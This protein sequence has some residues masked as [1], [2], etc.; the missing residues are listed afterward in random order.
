MEPTGNAASL[1]AVK[2]SN[3]IIGSGDAS[4][5]E[6]IEGTRKGLL[7]SRFSG[8]MRI[9]DGVVSGTVK[10]AIL[11]ENGERKFPV[12]ECM[13]VGNMYEFLKNITDLSRE[14]KRTTMAVITPWIKV[15]N[16]KFVGR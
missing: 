9:Q 12:R 1:L 4:K 15:E 8:M 6:I 7:V 14:T 3:T 2:P 16:V 5:E 13:L 11:I 10:Q